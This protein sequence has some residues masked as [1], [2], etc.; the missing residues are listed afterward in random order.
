MPSVGALTAV[1]FGQFDPLPLDLFDS[2]DMN[3]VSADDF[4]M[5][6]NFARIGHGD[7]P[8]KLPTITIDDRIGCIAAA[9]EILFTMT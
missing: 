8:L 3:A 4:H 7:P 1:S 2:A 5:P 6:A 9:W